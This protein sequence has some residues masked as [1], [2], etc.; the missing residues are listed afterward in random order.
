MKNAMFILLALVSMA[1]NVLADEFSAGEYRIETDEISGLEIFYDD[2]P[3]AVIKGISGLDKNGKW[4]GGHMLKSEFQVKNKDGVILLEYNITIDGILHKYVQTITL[5]KEGITV[6]REVVSAE[7]I[8]SL[9]MTILLSGTLYAG[10]KAVFLTNTDIRK[11][12][13]L[14]QEPPAKPLWNPSGMNGRISRACFSSKGKMVEFAFKSSNWSFSDSR[15]R[16]NPNF[17]LYRSFSKSDFGIAIAQAFS[18]SVN[19]ATGQ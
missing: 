7:D 16:K 19:K 9:D 15:T 3:L 2:E 4:F 14:L 12:I 11:S 5:S 18:I 8:R 6:E 10:E 13:E 1:A 17:T